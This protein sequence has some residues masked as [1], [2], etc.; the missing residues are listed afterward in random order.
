MLRYGSDAGQFT[1]H[2][3]H[4][5]GGVAATTYCVTNLGFKVM[6]KN[7]A[8]HSVMAM[9]SSAAGTQGNTTADA[10]VASTQPDCNIPPEYSVDVPL[11][12][13]TPGDSVRM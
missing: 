6:A 1:E 13:A 10:R 2:V 9:G 12:S 8:A 5:A 4:T 7:A 11:G 3:V